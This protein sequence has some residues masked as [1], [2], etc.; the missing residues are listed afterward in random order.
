M[1]EREDCREGGVEREPGAESVGFTLSAIK[2]KKTMLKKK[3]EKRKKKKEKHR[4]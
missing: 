4:M 1:D 3:K 2:N